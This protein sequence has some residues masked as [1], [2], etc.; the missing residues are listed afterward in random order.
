[1]FYAPNIIFACMDLF[2]Q[3]L[4]I[5]ATLTVMIGPITFTILETSLTGGISHGIATATGMW[6]S[7]ILYISLCY[8]GAQTLRE[9][10]QS[11]EMTQ[12][13]SEGDQLL[14]DTKTQRFFNQI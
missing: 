1:M 13:R 5:G 2:L 9:T 12:G 7:D 3:G 6:S 14:V 4:L 8:F 10:M 11:A